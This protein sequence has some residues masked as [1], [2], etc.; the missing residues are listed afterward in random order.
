[1]ALLTMYIGKKKLNLNGST[2]AELIGAADELPYIYINSNTSP[3]HNV[4]LWNIFFLNSSTD[5]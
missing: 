4:V 3:N 1:M 5:M 2:E